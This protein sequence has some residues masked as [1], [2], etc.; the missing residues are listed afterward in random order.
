LL[1][2]IALVLL[3][4]FLPGP[5][6]AQ[7][8]QM[9]PM[10][11]VSQQSFDSFTG[12]QIINAILNLKWGLIL[13]VFIIYFIGGYFIYSSMFAAMGS[14]INEDMGEGQQLMIPIV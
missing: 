8:S 12:Q 7:M 3:S 1:I 4:A 10:G 14:A 6:P 2:P 13:P 9:S 5:D 11:Q